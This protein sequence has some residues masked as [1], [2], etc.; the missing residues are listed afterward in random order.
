MPIR[1]RWTSHFITPE[2]ITSPLLQKTALLLK[3]ENFGQSLQLKY[4]KLNPYVN[5]VSFAGL[6]NQTFKFQVLKL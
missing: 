1:P 6:Q 4:V 3:F 2:S 5:S